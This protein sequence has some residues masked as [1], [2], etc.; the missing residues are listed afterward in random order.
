MGN[1]G[2]CNVGIEVFGIM[3]ENLMMIFGV[4]DS[5]IVFGDLVNF[6]EGVVIG[7]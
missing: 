4:V 3:V 7:F 2:D 5:E 1:N 6:D